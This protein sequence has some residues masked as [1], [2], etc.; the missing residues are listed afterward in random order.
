MSWSLIMLN[1]R[2]L[3]DDFRKEHPEFFTIDEEEE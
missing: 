1:K 3:Y 2:R